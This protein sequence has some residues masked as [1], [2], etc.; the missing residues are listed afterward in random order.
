MKW[1]KAG[2]EEYGAG[3]EMAAG[4]PGS[5]GEQQRGVERS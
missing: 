5:A 4:A 1:E 3:H 2:M